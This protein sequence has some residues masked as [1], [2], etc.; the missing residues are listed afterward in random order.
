MG[1]GINMITSRMTSDFEVKNGT[2][3]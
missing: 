3:F 2:L 1:R